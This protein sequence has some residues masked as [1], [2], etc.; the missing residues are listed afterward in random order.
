MAVVRL[1]SVT[2]TATVADAAAA[3]VPVIAPVAE[4]I[5][6]P[7][8]NPVADQVQVPLAPVAVTAVEY[9][10]PAVAAGN[11]AGPEI[12]SPEKTVNV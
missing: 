9:G 8:G 2:L 10:T 4:F 11:D 6:S 12:V 5:D 1:L 3:A 7:C